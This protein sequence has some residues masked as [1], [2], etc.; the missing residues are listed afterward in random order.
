MSGTATGRPRAQPPSLLGQRRKRH[1]ARLGLPGGQTVV[2]PAPGAGRMETQGAYFPISLKRFSMFP[3]LLSL[4]LS[5]SF[6]KEIS[7]LSFQWN[8]YI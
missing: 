3:S 1:Q 2:R 4:S 7:L 5:L 8:E 6:Q